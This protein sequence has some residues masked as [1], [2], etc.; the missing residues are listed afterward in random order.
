MSKRTDPFFKA[1]EALRQ[2]HDGNVSMTRDSMLAVL[3]T[4]IYVGSGPFTSYE[5]GE[6]WEAEWLSVAQPEWIDILLNIGLHPPDDID[7]VRE[8]W[9]LDLQLYMEAIAVRFPLYALHKI[10]QA[11]QEERTRGQVIGQ[12]LGKEYDEAPEWCK[13]LVRKSDQLSRADILRLVEVLNVVANTE[14]QS[15]LRQPGPRVQQSS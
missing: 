8:I 4:F 14:A 6:R 13:T 7:S 5:D 1:H 2:I 15:L 9:D 10:V 3:W 12:L 11:I